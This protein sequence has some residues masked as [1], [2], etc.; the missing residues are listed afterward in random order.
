MTYPSSTLPSP[1]LV[2]TMARPCL[3]P[4]QVDDVLAAFFVLVGVDPDNLPSL[5]TP[6][7]CSSPPSKPPRHM[8]SPTGPRTNISHRGH[9]KHQRQLLS[10][11]K[12]LSA[13]HIV[14]AGEMKSK[15]GSK[16]PSMTKHKKHRDRLVQSAPFLGAGTSLWGQQQQQRRM[17]Q[18]GALSV[19]RCLFA[20]DDDK[21][22]AS[23]K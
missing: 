16:E 23:S 18:L 13:G 20:T 8:T 15:K 10:S 21:E 4:K 9:V 11:K 2:P 19:R 22:N 14:P 3:S 1:D 17:Q 5:T 7:H 12:R 6:A